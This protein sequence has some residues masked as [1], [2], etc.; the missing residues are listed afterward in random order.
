MRARR[1]GMPF[2]MFM[3]TFFGVF[4]ISGRTKALQSRMIARPGA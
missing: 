1:P 3:S 4:V 2:Q